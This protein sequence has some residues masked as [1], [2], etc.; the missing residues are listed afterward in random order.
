[1]LIETLARALELKP[2]CLAG[3][4][5]NL[6]YWTDEVRTTLAGLGGYPKRFA[7]I[8]RAS[9]D[10]IAQRHLHADPQPRRRG[11]ERL[12]RPTLRVHEI[13]ALTSLLIEAFRR[14]LDR[15]VRA[16]LL[17]RGDAASVERIAGLPPRTGSREPEARGD[18]T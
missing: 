3:F 16:G 14:F 17:H 4:L 15:C 9:E 2:H 13:E 6:D 8:E 18:A 11:E 7:R 5:A 1:M 12:T 10:W